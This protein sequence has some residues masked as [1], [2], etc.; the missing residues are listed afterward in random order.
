MDT[1]LDKRR[2]KHATALVQER[3]AKIEKANAQSLQAQKSCWQ[4]PEKPR[5]YKAAVLSTEGP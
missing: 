3:T 1:K 5:P 4:S 2:F